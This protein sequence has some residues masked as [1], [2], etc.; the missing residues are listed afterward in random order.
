[1]RIHVPSSVDELAWFLAALVLCGS[2]LGILVA[3]LKG[4]G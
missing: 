1:M 2:G 4:E 3:L